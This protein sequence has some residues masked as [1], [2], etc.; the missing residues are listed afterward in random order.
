MVKKF[1]DFSI[2]EKR[3]DGDKIKI[4]EIL[5][6]EI[7]IIDFRIL[8]SKIN[9]NKDYLI[10]QFSINDKK[11]VFFS[12]SQVL[13]DQLTRYKDELPFLV[14]IIRTGRFYTLS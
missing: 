7:V 14:T 1:S 6:K 9:D 12:G 13:M 8:P 3:L 4:D 11:K 5:G 10:L 2:E